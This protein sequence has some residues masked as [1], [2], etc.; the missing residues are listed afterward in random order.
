MKIS[1]LIP[2]LENNVP[3]TY[4]PNTFPS[5]APD[6]SATVSIMD[7]SNQVVTHQA[8]VQVIVRGVD[9]S[10]VENKA[11]ELYNFLNQK[12]NFSVGNTHVAYCKANLATPIFYKKRCQ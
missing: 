1:E 9:D 3:Y 2:Y 12:V 5:T 7:G 4:Y 8:E 11:W 10:T 6:Q